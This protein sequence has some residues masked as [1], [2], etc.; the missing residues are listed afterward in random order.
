MLI[1]LMAALGC[2][3]SMSIT[4]LFPKSRVKLDKS[5]INEQF[6]IDSLFIPIDKS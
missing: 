4:P 6:S 1:K 5:D 2:K 3:L